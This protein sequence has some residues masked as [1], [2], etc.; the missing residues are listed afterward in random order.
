MMGSNS[1]AYL[2]PPLELSARLRLNCGAVA[3]IEPG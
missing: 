1:R 2:Q 3:T